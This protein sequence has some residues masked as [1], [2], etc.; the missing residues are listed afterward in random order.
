MEIAPILLFTYNRPAHT[1]RALASLQDNTLAGES[2]LFIY[3]DAPRN[4]ADRDAVDEVRRI[5]RNM[6]SSIPTGTSLTL[7]TS[8][9]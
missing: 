7:Q 8:R 2:E 3:S 4:E 5:I 9:R 1:R 6:F